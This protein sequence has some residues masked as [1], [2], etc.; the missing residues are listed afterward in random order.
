MDAEAILSQA[1][2][3]VQRHDGKFIRCHSELVSESQCKIIN[4]LSTSF[5]IYVSIQ[6][7]AFHSP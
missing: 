2:H 7:L 4:R 1:Q 6:Y 5:G 3:R